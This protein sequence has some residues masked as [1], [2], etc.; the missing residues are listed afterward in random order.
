MKI[1]RI[2]EKDNQ[3][4]KKII[5]NSLE[6]LDLALPGTAYFDPQLE[7]LTAYYAAFPNRDYWVVVDDEGEILGGCGIAAFDSEQKICELQK[8]Y[9]KSKA[10]GQG[11]SKALMRKALSFAAQHYDSCY[12]ETMDKMASANA[13]YRSFGFQALDKPLSGSSHDTMDCWYIK[14]LKE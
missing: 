13:L 12:L 5:Q 6:E 8:L 11:L 1:R 7:D 4:V 2:T 9:L 3:A 14:K 10:R